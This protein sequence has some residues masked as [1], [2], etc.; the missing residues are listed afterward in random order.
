MTS[1]ILLDTGPLG[2]VTNPR[3]SAE[4]REC[5]RWLEHMLINGR[6]VC[7]SEIADY[8]V[9]RELLRAGKTQGV[10]RLDAFKATICYMPLTTT[11]MLRAA[12]FWALARKQEKPTADDKALDGDVILAAQ[13]RVLQEQGECVVVATMNVGHLAQFVTAQ[14]WRTIV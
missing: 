4:T 9:R 13:A 7:I 1:L 10:R 6:Q 2:L 14:H 8:E 11:I 3:V 5:T 12:E